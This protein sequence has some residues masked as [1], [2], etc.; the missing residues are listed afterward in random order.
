MEAELQSKTSK[1]NVK[2]KR[3]NKTS[4]QKLDA[5]DA[6]ETQSRRGLQLLLTLAFPAVL[7]GSGA[8]G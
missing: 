2:T 1:Q 3:Q 7:C 6:E 8:P 4:K 5:E